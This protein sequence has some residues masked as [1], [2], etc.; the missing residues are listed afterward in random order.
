MFIPGIDRNGNLVCINDILVYFE[1]NKCKFV[2]VSHIDSS[3]VYT[4]RTTNNH[5]VRAY[6]LGRFTKLTNKQA[7]YAKLKGFI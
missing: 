1:N 2:Q 4:L 6:D 7:I 5:H 3:K